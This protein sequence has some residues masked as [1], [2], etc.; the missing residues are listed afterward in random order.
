[1]LHEGDFR[2]TIIDG[3]NSGRDT[4]SIG[5]M[6]GAILGA[7]QGSRHIT[8]DEKNLLSNKNKMQFDLLA[9][10]FSY[11]ARDIIANDLRLDQRKR[12]LIKNMME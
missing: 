6:A 10:Q 5:V 7:M 11:T 2:K 12:N 3:V 9:E 1:V 8:D 4:D